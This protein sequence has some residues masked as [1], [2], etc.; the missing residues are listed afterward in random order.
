MGSRVPR[1]QPD[2]PAVGAVTLRRLPQ[3]IVTDAEID[4]VHANANFGSMSRRW[5]VDE[6][7]LKFAFGY[8]CGYTQQQ[9]LI[10]HDLIR[11]RGMNERGELTAKGKQYLRALGPYI[12]DLIKKD[13]GF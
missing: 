9:I 11:F 8:H 3:D 2:F 13:K 5:V 7:V 12:F 10:E 4:R 6:G 1:H